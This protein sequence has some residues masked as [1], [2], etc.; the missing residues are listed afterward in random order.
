MPAERQRLPI[1]CAQIGER[2]R[3]PSISPTPRDS[4]LFEIWRP[5]ATLSVRI[6][7]SG[8]SSATGPTLRG[9]ERPTRPWSIVTCRALATTAPRAAGPVMDLSGREGL[10]EGRGGEGGDGQGRWRGAG[11]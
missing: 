11:E 4:R 8:R 5:V 6:S 1:I 2:K 3:L 10:E 7:Q 9:C